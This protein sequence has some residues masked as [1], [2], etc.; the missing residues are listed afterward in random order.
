[1]LIDE[2]DTFLGDNDEL[3]GILNGGH[4]R[5]SAY[6]WRSVGEDHEPRKFNVWA[7][8]RLLKNCGGWAV[9][10]CWLV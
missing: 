2:A 3:R 6:V 5:I 1:V 10:P 8:N 9:F 4:N 7:P